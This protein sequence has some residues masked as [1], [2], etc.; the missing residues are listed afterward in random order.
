LPVNKKNLD[1]ISKEVINFKNS[2]LCIVTKNRSEED[3]LS[4][5]SSGFEIF[6]E[7]RVQEAQ[8]KFTS[9]M[10]N[11]SKIK[12]HLIGPLQTNKAELALNLFDTIQTVDRL[13]LV[14]SIHKVS[15]NNT[16]KTSNFYIQINIGN[17]DQKSGVNPTDLKRLYDYSLEKNL[18]IS[19]LMC[20]PPANE[21]PIPYFKE[22]VS[23]KNEINR[24][25]LLSMGMSSDYLQALQNG[26]NLIRVGSKIF[27]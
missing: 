22:M 24:D 10:K 9:V 7:N 27:Q 25:L 19:G 5:V 11:N 14:D 18:N 21:D 1:K 8:K 23:L 20:I 2:N 15:K 17:E 3:I 6:G 16:V 12:L 4:L 26:S 13:K